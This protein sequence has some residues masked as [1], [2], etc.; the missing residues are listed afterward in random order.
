MLLSIKSHFVSNIGDTR[1]KQELE[2]TYYSR[3]Q[4]ELLVGCRQRCF[5]AQTTTLAM[6]SSSWA[7]RLVTS[8]PR[9]LRGFGAVLPVESSVD[10]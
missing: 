6:T 4:L 10:L 9:H 2:L 8:R 1:L 5:P 7:L 3:W